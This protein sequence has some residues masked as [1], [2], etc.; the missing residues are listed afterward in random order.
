MCNVEDLTQKC[1]NG[2]NITIPGRLSLD[3]CRSR[4]LQCRS[5]QPILSGAFAVAG[6]RRSEASRSLGPPERQDG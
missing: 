2:Q 4:C 6:P 1:T 3:G 5:G